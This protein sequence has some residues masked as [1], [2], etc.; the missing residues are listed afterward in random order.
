MIYRGPGFLAIMW[1][2]FSPSPL[3]KLSLFLS[4]PVCRR[5][6]LLTGKGVRGWGRS[7]IIRRRE[8]LFL[9]KS[10]STLWV[11]Y[12]EAA[13]HHTNM[14]V[15]CMCRPTWPGL[16]YRS[17]YSYDFLQLQGSVFHG[18]YYWLCCSFCP[19]LQ[20]CSVHYHL[21]SISCTP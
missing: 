8:C 4:I 1:L 16:T 5:L 6:S 11:N 10:F 3:S 17:S 13:S 14:H 21:S 19:I 18:V 2:S 7:Q 9:C 12:L 20:D 15:L